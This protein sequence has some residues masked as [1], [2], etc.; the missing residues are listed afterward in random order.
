MK[1]IILNGSPRKNW[2]T[3]QLLKE[4]KKGAESV[5]DEVEYFDLYDLKFTGC[6]SC[7]GCKRAGIENPCQCFWKDDLTPV[8]NKIL[9]SDRLIT[10]SPIFFG[11]PTGDFRS[12]LERL[13]FPLLS[14][15]DYSCLLKGK[16]NLD[17]F[18]TMN[19]TE[20]HYL[21]AYKAPLE[22]YFAPCRF[23][24]GQTRLHPVCDTLQ[25]GDYSKYEMRGFSEER[26][27]AR[28]EKE[29]PVALKLAFD[30][31]AGTATN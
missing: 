11:E 20:E 19:A 28:H 21:K 9:E 25:V 31:G 3:A 27:K 8:L 17:V 16:V 10:G 13:I 14:Y 2:N 30:V 5:G 18:F 4:A 15:N 6:R 22:A 7:L 23:L 29:F 26:K 12:F 1:T 24:N